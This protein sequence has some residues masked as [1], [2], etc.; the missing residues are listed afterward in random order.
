MRERRDLGAGASLRVVE[1]LVHRRHDRLAAVP[2]DERLEPPDARVVR[3][4]LG[5]QVA[6]GLMLGADLRQDQAEDVGNDP[7]RLDDLHRRDDHPLLE[8]LAKRADARRRAAADVD[9]VGEV[10]DVAEQLSAGV[11][12]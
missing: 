7:A 4:N 10:R 1:E 8:D 6:A 11:D 9:V 5:P 12:R 2:L 3:G